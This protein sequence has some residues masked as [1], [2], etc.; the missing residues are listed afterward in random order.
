[1]CSS[2]TY[3]HGT[4]NGTL[5]HGYTCPLTLTHLL[6]Y[7]ENKGLLLKW[8]SWMVNRHFLKKHCCSL[9]KLSS[10]NSLSI[11]IS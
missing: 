7:S 8:E 1:M 3:P 5:Q 11:G 10:P 6:D 2:G 9:Q 4:R